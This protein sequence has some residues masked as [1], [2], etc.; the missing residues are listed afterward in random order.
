MK[1]DKESTVPCI[2][3]GA[4]AK[5]VVQSRADMK[6]QLDDVEPGDDGTGEGGRPYPVF[7]GKLAKQ[8]WMPHPP[9]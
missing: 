1:D 7:C 2:L 6:Q 4:D 9:Y 8:R 5:T 3:G